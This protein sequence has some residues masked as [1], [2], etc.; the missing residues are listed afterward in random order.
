VRG[1]GCTLQGAGC[2][3]QGAGSTV[4]GLGFRI[5]GIEEGLQDS[6]LRVKGSKYRNYIY[7]SC[8]FEV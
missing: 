5:F 6:R 8:T 4:W 3:V 7:L 2:R 1:A